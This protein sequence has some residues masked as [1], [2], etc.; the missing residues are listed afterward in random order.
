MIIMNDLK[1]VRD[2]CGVTTIRPNGRILASAM[3][4]PHV[5]DKE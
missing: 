2:D 3:G 1:A 5:G 4:R